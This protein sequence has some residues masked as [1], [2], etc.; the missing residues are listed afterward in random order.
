MF[1]VFA[2]FVIPPLFGALTA[3][4]GPLLPIKTYRDPA[5]IVEYIEDRPRPLAFYVYTKDKQLAD[6]YINN[7]MSGGVSVNDGLLHA[8]LHDLPFGGVGNSGMGHYHGKEGFLTFSKQRPVF[9]QGPL[10]AM[11]LLM[12]PYKGRA[13]KLLDFTLKQ[14]S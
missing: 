6:W 10:R 2:A 1:A 11:N 3:V 4:F 7:T 9:Y 14:S 12:P 8:A 5:E 13:S